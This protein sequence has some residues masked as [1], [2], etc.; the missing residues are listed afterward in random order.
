MGEAANT[1]IQHDFGFPQ[2][3]RAETDLKLF[4]VEAWCPRIIIREKP[5]WSL[6]DSLGRL[7]NE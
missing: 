2:V 4:L 1:V 3:V 6:A 5:Q 7:A